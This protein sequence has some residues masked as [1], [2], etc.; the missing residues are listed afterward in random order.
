MEAP[1]D[2]NWPRQ[3]VRHQRTISYCQLQLSICLKSLKR[4]HSYHFCFSIICTLW[5]FVILHWGTQINGKQGFYKCSTIQVQTVYIQAISYSLYALYICGEHFC[6]SYLVKLFLFSDQ[7]LS[8]ASPELCIQL[9]QFPT[10]NNFIGLRNRIGCAAMDINKQG[11]QLALKILVFVVLG[12]KELFS[13]VY[14]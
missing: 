2:T 6:W 11:Q 8:G 10:V 7:N 4:T 3:Q 5:I 9:L 12:C 1:Q 14:Y 13:V